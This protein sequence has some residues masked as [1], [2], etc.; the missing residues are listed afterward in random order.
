V[1]HAYGIYYALLWEVHIII[2]YL[3]LVGELF[4]MTA[5]SLNHSCGCI[6]LTVYL[7]KLQGLFN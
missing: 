2:R 1:S 5:K 3:F 7:H 4:I 6:N